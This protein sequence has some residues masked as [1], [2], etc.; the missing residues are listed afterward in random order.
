MHI[1]KV[2]NINCPHVKPKQA[3]QYHRKKQYHCQSIYDFLGKD[4]QLVIEHGKVDFIKHV[5]DPHRVFFIG[6]NDYMVK[7]DKGEIIVFTYEE[8]MKNYRLE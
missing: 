7:N 1:Y 8:L 5:T 3:L 6:D 4:Y 2:I